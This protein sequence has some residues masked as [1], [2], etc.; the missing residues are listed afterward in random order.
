MMRECVLFRDI[1]SLINV[2]G[3]REKSSLG[4]L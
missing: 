2:H 3:I 4:D 1:S